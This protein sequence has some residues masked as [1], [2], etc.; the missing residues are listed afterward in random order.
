VPGFHVLKPET[1]RESCI[2][3]ADHLFQ[4]DWTKLQAGCDYGSP[5]QTLNILAGNL[6]FSLESALTLGGA[7]WLNATKRIGANCVLP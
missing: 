2:P 5:F 4:E 3:Q 1:Y 6:L 7:E